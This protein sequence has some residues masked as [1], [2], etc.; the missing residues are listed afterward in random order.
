MSNY[1]FR[2]ENFPPL[3]V[4]PE[5]MDMALDF[6]DGRVFVTATLRLTARRTLDAVILDA[7]EL[8]IQSV[9][10]LD[11]AG[12]EHPLPFILRPETRKLEIA[13]GETLPAHARLTIRTRTVCTPSDRILE[14]IYLDSTPPGCPQQYMS[15]CQQ[16]GFQRI[17]PVL[18]DCTA[19]CTFTTTIE[20][21]ARYTHLISNGNV[22]RQ[23]N[24]SGKPEPKP[25]DPSR[26][27]I[28]YENMIPMAPYLFLCCVGTWDALEDEAVYPDGR[29][30]KLQYLVPP[31]RLEGARGPMAILKDSALWQGRTQDYR[32][33]REVYRTITMEKSNFGGMENV[34]NTTIVTDAAL[35][36]GCTSDRRLLYAHAVIV[37]EFEHN[38]C[39]SD[40]TMETPF[41]M[42]LNEA[43]TVDVERQYM[44]DRF[45]PDGM[46]LDEVDSMRDPVHGP[47]AIEQGGHL[48]RIVR[49]G[50]NDPDELVDGVTYVKAAEVIRMLKLLLG[51]EVFRKAKTLYFSRYDGGNANTDQFFA[52]FAEA[53]GRDLG[54]FRRE[55]L[56]TIGYPV[57][58]AEHTY[59]PA[60]RRLRVRLTQR[61]TGVGGLFHVPLRLAAVDAAGR[62]IPGTDRLVELT[63]PVHEEVFENVAAP[64]FLSLNRDCSFY[65]V[66]EDSGATPE[67]L[68]L[69]IRLDSNR[70]NRV[71]AMRRLTERERARLL[72]DPAAAVS[73]DWIATYVSLVRDGS[74]PAGFKAA[75]L[76]IDETPLDRT[77][78]PRVRELYA[79]RLKLLGA[80][81]KAHFAEVAAA[82]QAVDTYQPEAKPGAG[83]EARRLKSALLRVLAEARSPE[84]H[85]LAETHFRKAWNITDQLSALAAVQLS[86]HPKRAAIFEEAYGL[87][88]DKLSAYTAYLATVGS[89]ARGPE[90]LEAVRKE[91][92]R[93][94]FRIEH[95]SH[96]RSL[97]LPLA[98]NSGVL[99]T[100]AGLAWA[101]ETVIRLAP[102]SEY[103]TQHLLASFQLFRQFEPGLQQQARMALLEMRGAL[104][105]DKTPAVCGRLDSYLAAP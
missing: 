7:R 35:I 41:D 21:D 64:A 56:H 37:H 69:Q 48:G 71:E 42:W 13:L 86:D 91:A 58:A 31:G 45:D 30:V 87:W 76:R 6:R 15:Q 44:A 46:R 20:A 83:I 29:C 65:G 1:R 90:V 77:L 9:V 68:K 63:G 52:C 75:L 26:Q 78:L 85:A 50:F 99:W 22:S 51:R 96:C 80:V 101:V 28:T 39:G 57:V 74:L 40:V 34:G 73:P 53:S 81:A 47:L 8:E 36:D 16:W 23:R 93:P 84:A 33:P 59:D 55:W 5:H 102:V 62:D 4:K 10:R 82:F 88:R 67:S 11:G 49:E 61:R 32:Y 2:R 98:G 100:E 60:A 70:F 19:K 25:G 18:D 103:V 43:F 97:F 89:S 38:Q 94:D 17:A 12:G 14:G 72:A 92:A 79:V 105:P 3:P 95:P 24:P 104:D 66:F 27:V 54:Q